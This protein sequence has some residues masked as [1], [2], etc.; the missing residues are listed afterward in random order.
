MKKNRIISL[1]GTALVLI[2]GACQP[3]DD[4]EVL[5]ST[6]SIDD[7]VLTSS[8]ATEGGNLI[9]LNMETPGITGY[10]DYNLGKALTNKF[11]FIYPIPGNNTFTYVGTL[12]SEFFTKTIE[13]QVDVLDH[14]L[15]Q[16]WYDL[17]GE[18]TEAGKT[19]VFNGGPEPDGGLWWYM[20]AN[21]DSSQWE[22]A[23]WNAAG[24][25][26]PPVDAA[27]RMT[28]DLDGAANFTY[29][30]GP[31]AAPQAARF[32][33]DPAKQTLQ[34]DGANILGAEEPRGNPAGLYTIISLTED[35]LI[36]YVPNNA[37]GTGWVWVFKPEE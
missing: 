16:D 4:R 21:D 23:W 32:V 5:E 28:F 17:V 14:E 26:C 35:E 33:L 29:Y 19:W 13:V 12:G 34:I 30:A 11:E 3:I 15:N 22:G 10:W 6:V 37:G 18:D 7:I 31:D 36:L 1:L 20:A 27:G 24:E 25:C 2:L 8:Q 9:E